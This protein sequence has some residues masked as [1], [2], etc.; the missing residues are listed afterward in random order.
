M[1]PTWQWK[2]QMTLVDTQGEVT[3]LTYETRCCF[4][5]TASARA[6]DAAERWAKS[7]GWANPNQITKSI[8][9]VERVEGTSSDNRKG[10][11]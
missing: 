4:M 8:V 3:R 7:E 9:I 11:E 1:T 10:K 2:A 5:H 6:A